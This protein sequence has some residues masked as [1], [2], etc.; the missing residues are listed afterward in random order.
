MSK[1]HPRRRL[2]AWVAI[3][4]ATFAGA[5][6][7]GPVR[8]RAETPAGQPP[9]ERLAFEGSAF[10]VCRYHP[11]V[12]ALQIAWKGPDGP[13]GGFDTLAGALGADGTRLLFAM[14]A[15][16][17]DRAQAP[18]GLLVQAGAV[19]HPADTGSGRGNFY[20][21]PNGVFSVDPDGTVHVEETQ[22]FLGRHAAPTWAT[23]SGPLLVEGGVLHPK[24]AEDGD[25]RLVRNGVGVPGPGEADFVISEGRVSFGR[26]A[27]FFRD[28]LHC[29][30][31]LYLDG[32]V[33]SLWAPNLKRR[34]RAAG[35]GPLVVV[36]A[37]P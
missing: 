22:S 18:V 37:K 17:F 21:L 23:Q 2:P 14:N 25:S 31:A 3:A 36:T 5:I 32:T 19:A 11:G 4:I 34:D 27:R 13:L 10:I 20:L 35:L 6:S 24:I 29:P 15:G 8:A 1:A 28:V 9:C 33:S 26:L 30:D 7:A 12:E 16:M